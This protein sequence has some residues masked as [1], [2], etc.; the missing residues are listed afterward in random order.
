M[1]ADDPGVVFE[2]IE[3]IDHQRAL[4]SKADVSP[5][6][7]VA[8][9]DQDRVG[10]FPLPAPDLRRATRQSAAIWISVVVGGWQDMTVQVR[11]VQDRNTNRVGI[12]RSSSTRERRDG[13]NQ[14]RLAGEFQKFP[15]SPRCV[16]V[17]HRLFQ[18]ADI[19]ALRQPISQ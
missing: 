1:I 10:A 11:R 7:H 8:D 17:K 5:L 14:S 3:Q 16:R 4:V 13:A 15:A 19:L 12:E 2:M 18:W 6:I 9:V